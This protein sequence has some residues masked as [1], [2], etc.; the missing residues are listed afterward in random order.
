MPADSYPSNFSTAFEFLREQL[1]CP[2]C[3]GELRMEAERL[4]CVRCGGEYPI[5]DGIPVLTPAVGDP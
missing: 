2:G 1:A 4:E 5:V 3:Q